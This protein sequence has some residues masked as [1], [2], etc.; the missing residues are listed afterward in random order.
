MSTAL[1]LSREACPHGA[2]RRLAHHD[3]T[4]IARILGTPWCGPAPRS[5]GYF[6]SVGR[7]AVLASGSGTILRSMLD[8]RPPDRGRARRP[9][10]RG[11]RDRR[12][13]RRRRPSSSSAPRSGPTSTASPTPTRCSTPSRATASTWSR[14]P[15]SAPSWPKPIHDAFPDRIVNTHPA[16]LPAFKG[17][18]AVDDALA[19]GVKVTGCTVHLP[20]SR[21]TRARSSP[22]KRCRCCPTT[23]SSRSTNGS[24]K[25]NGGSTRKCCESWS[26][27]ANQ[28]HEGAAL[29]VRQERASSSSPASCS[30]RGVELVSSGGTAT[31]IADAG[32]PR[33]RRSP[34]SPASRPS[35]TTGSSR[36]TRRSTAASS[37]TARSRRTDADMADVRHPAVRPR[38]RRTSTRSR[39]APDIETIDIGGPAMVRAAAKNHAFVTIV[40]DPADYVP[41]LEELAPTTA[42]SATRRAD[43]FALA[44]VRAHRG[45]RRRRSWRGCNGDGPLPPYIDLALERTGEALRYGENPHQHAARYRIAGTSSWWDD[46]QQHG[47]LALSLPQPLRRRRRV[48]PGPRPRRRRPRSRSSSTPIPCGVARRRRPRHRVPACARV[49]RALGLRRHRRAQPAGRRRHRRSAWSRARRPTSCIA[50][51]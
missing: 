51:G 26:N 23:R 45:V 27:D 46:V 29:G 42:P 39:S 19:Y 5:L 10:V 38:R 34:T 25:S 9:S 3:L 47:G 24:R 33:H 11:A 12:G 1:S 13:G 36:C 44:G 35:S 31:A 37:P 30:E 2:H 8:A 6:R 43:A 22:R 50:P 49:R 21:S 17:W 15:G 16:L 48:A 40:T 28:D 4:L 7:M 14:W 41:L 18:H 20:G 32:H